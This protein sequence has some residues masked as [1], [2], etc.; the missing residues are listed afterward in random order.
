MMVNPNKRPVLNATF[1]DSNGVERECN[2]WYPLPF[3]RV[4]NGYAMSWLPVEIGQG[5][6]PRLRCRLADGR[7]VDWR[8]FGHLPAE[9]VEWMLVD[10][11]AYEI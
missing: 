10:N 5:L 2:V 7:V 9:P 4:V 11:G 6:T 3:V 8:P 1:V